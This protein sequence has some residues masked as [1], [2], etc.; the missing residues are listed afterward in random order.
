METV[1]I[2][3]RGRHC[4]LRVRYVASHDE[5]DAFLASLLNF[6]AFDN[7]AEDRRLQI[8]LRCLCGVY[9][10]VTAIDLD[11]G[12]GTTIFRGNTSIPSIREGQN[13][14]DTLRWFGKRLVHTDD[15]DR[16]VRFM[17]LDSVASRT[18]KSGN[19]HIVDAFRMLQGRGSYDWI[20]CVLIPT[21]DKGSRA[22]L[23]CMR[24]T[25]E[26]VLST[27]EEN[28]TI[29]KS[30]LWDTLIDLIPAGVFWKNAQRRFLGVN[31]NFLDFY[32]FESTKDVL[33][34]NDED[35]G[36]HVETDPF[37]NDELRVLEQGELILNAQ[38]TCIA[39]GEV[40]TIRANKVPIRKNGEIIGLLGFFVDETDRGSGVQS[41]S[42][43]GSARMAEVDE[44][45]GI[46]NLQGIAASAIS[47]QQAYRETGI[48]FVFV[49]VDIRD[50]GGLNE[51][52]GRIFGNRILKTVAQGLVRMCGVSGVVARI[53]GDKFAVMRQITSPR[54]AEKVTQK[55]RMSVATITEVDGIPVELGCSIGWAL[56]VEGEDISDVIALADNRLH[57][58]RGY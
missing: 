22:V 24:R 35:M 18:E 43:D 48:E 55:I 10:Q 5:T 52:Y 57:E 1:D 11:E 17:D 14:R 33:G 25:N 56:N 39:R 3:A 30:V 9:D 54:D 13:V 12:T 32:E 42:F 40:H 46:P 50:M 15:R 8:A 2:L 45:T 20:T 34:K 53:S 41:T 38:G 29:P 44:L 28:T 23:L 58:A 37:K 6:S 4:V 47:Y 21:E 51:V 31:R 49:L 16:F 7:V 36:W 27:I 19:G 26:G